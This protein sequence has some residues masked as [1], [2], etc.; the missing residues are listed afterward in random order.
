MAYRFPPPERGAAAPP[1]G[2]P[3]DGLA[4]APAP[5]PRPSRSRRLHEPAPRP[6]PPAAPLSRAADPPSVP[7]VGMVATVR[8]RRA[9]IAG[10]D[11]TVGRDKRLRLVQMDYLDHHSPPSERLVWEIEPGAHLHEPNDVP[12]GDA[13]PMPPADFDALLRAA[14]WTALTPYLEEDDAEDPPPSSPFHGGVRIEPYQLV[15]LV[16]ALRMPRVNLLIADDVGLGKTVEAGLILAELLLRRRIRR[17]LVLTPASLRRQWKE[18][19]REKFALRFE[20]VDRRETEHLRRS[21][22]MDANP[23]RSHDRIVASYHYLRQPEIR[24]QF[25][26][27]HRRPKDAP[28][29]A[30]LPWDL[31]IVDECH[32]LMPA[33]VGEDSE[34]CRTLREIAP[35]FEHRLFLSAT[36]HNGHT[37]SFTGLLEML[38]PVRFHRTSRMTPALRRRTGEVVV[39]RLKRHL[40]PSANGDTEGDTHEPRRFCRRLPPEALPL[41]DDPLEAELSAAFSDFRARLHQLVRATADG[42]RRAGN[43]AVEVLNKRLLSCPTAFAESWRRVLAG[44]ADPPAE[45][46]Q[47]MAEKRSLDRDTGDDRETERREAVAAEV[48]GSWLRNYEADLGPQIERLRAAL[49]SLGFDLAGKPTVEQDPAADTRLDALTALIEDHLRDGGAFR[50]DERLIVFTEYKTTLDYLTRRLRGRYPAERVL[51]LFGAGGAEGMGEDDREAVKSAFNDPGASVRILVATDAASEGLNLQ[52][53]ARRLLHYDCPW[54]PSRLEQRNGRLDRYGQGREV[55]IHH[56]LSGSD[57]DLRFL[58]R[59]VQKANEM[60]DD[61][62]SVNE[63]FDRAV[64]RRLI[65]GEQP[66]LV[67][68]EFERSLET[69]REGAH[70]DADESATTGVTDFRERLDLHPDALRH[71]LAA[72]LGTAGGARPLTPAADQPGAFTVGNP[73][74]PGW[75]EVFDSEV[76]LSANGAGL[77]PMPRLAFDERPFLEA[78]G[79]LTVFRP[80]PEMQLVHLAHPLLRRSL[81]VLARRRYPGTGATVSRWTARRGGFSPQTL[82]GA[83]R[84]AEAVALFSVEEFA[85]NELREPFHRWVRTLAFPVRGGELGDALPEEA[86]RRIAAAEAVPDPEDEEARELLDEVGPALKKRLSSHRWQ[87]GRDIRAALER[88]GET[89]KRRETEEY[90]RRQ[91]EVSELITGNKLE[92]IERDLAALKEESERRMLFDTEERAARISR[93]RDLLEEEHRRTLEGHEALRRNL[94]EERDRILNRLVPARYSLAGEVQVFPVTVEIRLPEKRG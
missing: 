49:E 51:T 23:W 82:P 20:I 26:S 80:R 34:L 42:R 13:P 37:R 1:R 68:P 85:V 52:R 27:A 81:A 72:A 83:A 63:V 59:L 92:K 62:G 56:F 32:N 15:P 29:S 84:G 33:P 78:C 50:G 91:A 44:L 19:M 16:K 88:R 39:R 22:G 70:Y 87:L 53:T 18:E 2:A 75:R 38:D 4:D 65:R 12:N 76:R 89:A 90:D 21:L 30:R 69:A 3:R 61:L 14:R 10:V 24:E 11:E 40:D 57:P 9:V 86:T 54:N 8:N 25:H 55:S 67:V 66:Q 31:L 94:A 77:G 58:A 60:R 45:D 41:R 48:T 47:L 6:D 36:P 5:L 79:S 28:P 74:L 17:V 71:T 64:H 93:S 46:A 35:H 7:R 73:D 43:F